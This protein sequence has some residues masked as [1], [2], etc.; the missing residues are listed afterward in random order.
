MTDL[1]AT[2]KE[3]ALGQVATTQLGRMLSSRRETGQHGKPYLRNRDVQW[4]AI[5]TSDLPVMDF[6]PKDAARFSLRPG[7]VLVCEGGEVGRSAIWKGELAECY[8]QKALHRVRTSDELRPQ[9]LAYLLEYYARTRAFERYTTGSTIAH[10][11]QEDLRKLPIPLPPNDEQSR[12]IA[13]IEEQFSRLEAGTAILQRA[14]LNIKRLRDAIMFAATL[15]RLVRQDPSDEPAASLISKVKTTGRFQGKGALPAGLAPLPKGWCW[16]M[17]GSL[18]QRVTVGHVGPMK[19]E[20][21]D[22]GIPFLR[23]QNVRENRFDPKGIRFISPSFHAQ[24]TKSRLLPGDLVVVRSGNVGTACVIPESLEEANCADLVIVQRPEAVDP[25]YAALYMNSL[26]RSRVRA[27]KVGVALTHFNTQSVAELPVPV[28]PMNEQKRIVA[29]AQI[30]LSA[31]DSLET[32]IIKGLRRSA[33]MR[34]SILTAAFT[35][36]LL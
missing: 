24:I 21:I 15:G 5:N 27:G 4:G 19:N 35:G 25:H 6:G 9:F 32:E 30:L 8:Y 17:M 36:E 31:V 14:Q 33:A 34:S 18:A 26:A 10:L 13:A 29:R 3:V 1:P 22:D 7:D 23:S 11:P 2:W 12:I 16:A 28:P 20:Y